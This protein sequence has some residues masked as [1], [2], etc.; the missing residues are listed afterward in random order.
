MGKKMHYFMPDNK[1]QSVEFHH[2]TSSAPEKFK[3]R[4]M[5]GQDQAPS[6]VGCWG[7]GA[8]LI[9]AYLP[10]LSC[11]VKQLDSWKHNLHGKGCPSTWQCWQAQKCE[12]D[13][14]VLMP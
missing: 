2:K 7:H 14:I 1:R 10:T 5:H 3:T 9:H 6:S 4:G 8:F 13:C 12:N 11:A